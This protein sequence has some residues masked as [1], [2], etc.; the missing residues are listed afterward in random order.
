MVPHMAMRVRMSVPVP[1]EWTAELVLLLVNA[2][3]LPLDDVVLRARDHPRVLLAA[4]ARPELHGLVDRG[5]NVHH[6]CALDE[7]LELDHRG[8]LLAGRP[9]LVRDHDRVH[10]LLGPGILNFERLLVLESLRTEA[11][12][13]SH[14]V[15]GS[16][17][18]IC[19]TEAA[20]HGLGTELVLHGRAAKSRSVYG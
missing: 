12:H 5:G 19:E 8:Q 10:E 2:N 14:R 9:G 6:A 20:T 11:A 15:D 16:Q 1:N 18:T 7:W 3:G 4:R 13:N 17:V